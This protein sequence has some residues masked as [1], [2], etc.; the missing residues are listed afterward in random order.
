M[1][2]QRLIGDPLLLQARCAVQLARLAAV[3]AR[4]SPGPRG[5]SP[6]GRGSRSTRQSPRAVGAPAP[7]VHRPS[8]CNQPLRPIAP[9]DGSARRTGRSSTTGKR[10]G[11]ARSRLD[12]SVDREDSARTASTNTV[13]PSA[14]CPQPVRPPQHSVTAAATAGALRSSRRHRRDPVAPPADPLSRPGG[15]EEEGRRHAPGQHVVGHRPAAPDVVYVVLVSSSSTQ[16]PDYPL[17]IFAAILP[18]KWFTAVVGDAISS[19]VSSQERLIKQIQFPKLVLPIAAA[20]A[21]IVELRVRAHPA[22][23]ADDPVL[24]DRIIAVSAVHPGHRRSSSSSSHCRSAIA[25]SARQRLLPGPRQRRAPR[26][27]ALVLPLAGPVRVAEL[28]E[29]DVTEKTHRWHAHAAQPVRDAV[30]VV[31]RGDLRRRRPATAARPT[32]RPGRAPRGSSSCSASRPRSS[33]GSSRRSRRSCDRGSRPR[34]G[35]ARAD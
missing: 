24:R 29:L 12:P 6:R 27:A 1:W 32:G 7:S 17:F 16:P 4:G 34:A 26:A 23:G 2:F 33:S 21:G 18:W 11:D 15:H 19:V 10:S 8:R 28:I 14:R 22:G 20:M 9:F 13:L 31:P 5:A 35:I 3:H 25:V 30:H